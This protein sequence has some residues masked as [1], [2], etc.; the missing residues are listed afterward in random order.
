VNFALPRVSVNGREI[1]I[2]GLHGNDR[3]TIMDA[4]GHV[5]WS[6]SAGIHKMPVG[7]YFVTV[8]GS[9]RSYTQKIAIR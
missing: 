5:V 6:G 4:M 8:R 7:N 1:S 2:S 3:V 9:T